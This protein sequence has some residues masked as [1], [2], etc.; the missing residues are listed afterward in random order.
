MR[1][2]ERVRYFFAAHWR[3]LV[4]GFFAGILVALPL[5]A[6]W[7]GGVIPD[8]AGNLWGAALGAG[9]AVVGAAWVERSRGQSA[10][11]EVAVFLVS[12]LQRPR[13]AAYRVTS[14]RVSRLESDPWRESDFEEVA[15]S[16]R[17]ALE[18]IGKSQSGIAIV[19]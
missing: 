3:P 7:M 8:G 18:W 2:S 14:S 16:A 4:I 15:S 13:D 1:I 19:G 9:M 12:V 17:R 11:R 5:A 10:A 6:P